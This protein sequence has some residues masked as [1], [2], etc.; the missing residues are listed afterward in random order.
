MHSSVSTPKEYINSLPDDRKRAVAKLRNVVK[1]NLP[2]GF[3]EVM[4]SGML[5]YVVP[6]SLYPAGYRRNP[7]E[8]LPF[9]G[10][11]S[12]KHFIA[13]YSMGLLGNK[14]LLDWFTAEYSKVLPTRLDMGKSCIR[15]KNPDHIP[16]QLMGELASKITPQQWIERYEKYRQKKY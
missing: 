1:Q 8:P 5:G 14:K 6:L 12:Q 4:G 3:V 11:G 13:F 9:M 15:F 7:K 16:F 10:I 2:K